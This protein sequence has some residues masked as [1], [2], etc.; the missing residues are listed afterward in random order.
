VSSVSFIDTLPVDKHA[1]HSIRY[2][3]KVDIIWTVISTNYPELRQNEVSKDITH[4]PIITRGL[5]IK[6]TVH[7]TDTVSV[8]VGCSSTMGRGIFK[9]I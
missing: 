5:T 7:H 3:F 8:I 9:V 6:T 4:K 1:L 2:R